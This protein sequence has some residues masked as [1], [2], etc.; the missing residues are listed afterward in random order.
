MA[1]E[2]TAAGANTGATPQG[3]PAP[4]AER[5]KISDM[6]RT[7]SHGVPAAPAPLV[8]HQGREA[9]PVGDV[10]PRGNKPPPLGFDDSGNP[11]LG[12]G[13]DLDAE[14]HAL[15]RE[16]D[17]LGAELDEYGNDPNQLEL[18]DSAPSEL[19]EPDEWD[20][21]KQ[22]FT[23]KDVRALIESDDIPEVFDDK[24]WTYVPLTNR[25]GTSFMK[26]ETLGEVKRGYMRRE[27]HSQ[28]CGEVAE[29]RRNVLAVQQG[30]QRMIQDLNGPPPSFMQAMRIMNV[31]PQFIAAAEWYA[32]EVALPEQQLRS[33]NPQAYE[34]YIARK[35]A[36][37]RAIEL[38]RQANI[39]IQQAQQLAQQ[40]PQQPGPDAQ[41]IAH[42]LA[43]MMPIALKRARIDEAKQRSASFKLIWDEPVGQNQTRS[44]QIFGIHFANLVT[45]LQGPI[46]TQFVHDVVEAT[47]ETVEQLAREMQPQR[48]PAVT[49]AAPAPNPGGAARNGSRQP[50]RA[51]IGDMTRML[52]NT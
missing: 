51:K 24:K 26:R 37:E 7:L 15:Q 10:Q 1:G 34:Q 27:D 6:S 18:D 40:Q 44:E 16:A 21:I 36:E 33:Q 20:A 5:A 41:Q 17:G 52:R 2:A 50:Q 29:I 11:D 4:V 25:D 47:K 19:V 43:Q 35:Q 14:A 46:T 3:A 32:K 49:A 42:Q 48:R 38:Q 31:V 39:A 9:T 12:M 30:Q 23:S 8:I 45:G 13:G 28:K 22:T